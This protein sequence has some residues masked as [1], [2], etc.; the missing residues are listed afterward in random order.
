MSLKSSAQSVNQKHLLTEDLTIIQ[1][2]FLDYFLIS[3]RS[4]FSYFRRVG[5][6]VQLFVRF[7]NTVCTK[8]G[9]GRIT[10]N[11]LTRLRFM[12]SLIK[13]YLLLT[14]KGNYIKKEKKKKIWTVMFGQELLSWPWNSIVLTYNSPPLSFLLAY[15]LCLHIM[16][17]HHLFI[18][19]ACPRQSS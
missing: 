16:L 15:T 7:Y 2:P 17:M 14:E 12:E 18:S 11:Y 5:C 6:S 13:G 8:I 10:E 1:N 4:G 3:F 19:K 9:Q